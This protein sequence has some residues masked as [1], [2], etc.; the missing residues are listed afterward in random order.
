MS[1]CGTTINTDTDTDT[2]T[3]TIHTEF[4]ELL[5]AQISSEATL[6]QY[7]N[8]DADTIT[9][10]PAVDS[11]HADWQQECREKALPWRYNT[12]Q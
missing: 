5:F 10:E 7:M 12:K 11:T 2:D 8:F 6:D 3:D 4:Q 1:Y 9:S